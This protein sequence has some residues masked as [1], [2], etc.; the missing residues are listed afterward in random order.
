VISYQHEASLRGII[1]GIDEAGRGALVGGVFAA[2]V[3][4]DPACIPDGLNDS[5]KLSKHTRERL[6]EAIWATGQVGVGV[7]S[8]TEIDQCNILQATML[9]MQRAFHALPC[10]PNHALIDGN[11]APVLPCATHTMIQGDTLSLSIAA[12]SIIAKVA[13]DA[14]MQELHVLMPH[15]GFD[16]HAGYGTKVHLEALRVHGASTEHR[17]TF[18]PVR[19]VIANARC[20]H[21]SEQK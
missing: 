15:Y 7:A 12:A 3:V 2:A 18:R 19:E 6:A 10:A 8:C 4:L 13:R 14:A 11:R 21:T 16:R 20:G 1:C 17:R 9:A 5:K